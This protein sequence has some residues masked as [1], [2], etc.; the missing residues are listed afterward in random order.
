MQDTVLYPAFAG[1][2]L[3]LVASVTAVTRFPTTA[4][5]VLALDTLTPVLVA[6]VALYGVSTHSPYHPDAVPILAPLAF[7]GT[8]VAAGYYEERKIF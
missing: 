2:K 6:L 7:I 5:R 4:N 1:T 3:L 8:M